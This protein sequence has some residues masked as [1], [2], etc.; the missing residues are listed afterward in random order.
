[1]RSAAIVPARNEAATVAEVVRVARASPLIDEVIVVDGASTDGTG[2]LARRAGA[3]VIGVREPGK[4]QAML[5]G[6]S[7]TD[8]EVLVFLDGD[9]TGLAPHHVD[10]LARPVR[11]GSAV[12]V[13]G[14]FDRGRL[15]TTVFLHL[16]P[17]LTGERA[18]RRELLASLAPDDV[19]GYRVEAA[20]NCRAADAGEPVA[21]FV[22][23]GMFH[24]TKEQKL[25]GLRGL[26]AK[27]AMLATAYATYRRYRRRYGRWHRPTRLTGEAALR[28]NGGGGR[29]APPLTVPAPLHRAARW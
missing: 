27:L 19:A 8:A 13:C 21:A 16:L 15:L 4:G 5:A 12:M 1:M 11:S 23:H 28:P 7:A 18:L 6:L 3:R 29:T 14:L 25:G 20:L 2:E 26:V 9:L 10:R 22:C 17:I 24:A